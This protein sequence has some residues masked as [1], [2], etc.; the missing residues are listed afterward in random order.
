MGY[1]TLKEARGAAQST[2]RKSFSQRSSSQILREAIASSTDYQ[3]YDIFLSHSFKDAELILGMKSIL[4]DQG[5]SVYVDWHDDPQMS[6]ESVSKET[7]EI[8]RKRMRQSK[9]LIY[10]ATD[11]ASGSKWMPWELGYFDGYKP[12]GVAILPLME[13]ESSSFKGQEYLSLYPVVQKRKY[14]SGA[15]DVFVEESGKEWDTLKN[16]G[17]GTSNWRKY[18]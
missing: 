2:L 11:N 10:V 14:T 6:R 1:Y 18:A 8:L 17:R 4:E 9:S 16:F 7:A 3:S 12:K 5:F 15:T 13:Y